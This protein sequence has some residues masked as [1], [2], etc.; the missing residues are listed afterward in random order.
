MDCSEDIFGLVYTW[1][2][3]SSGHEWFLKVSYVRLISS[4]TMPTTLD[5]PY[6]TVLLYCMITMILVDCKITNFCLYMY[7]CQ[8]AWKRELQLNTSFVNSFSD[9]NCVVIVPADKLVKF[10]ARF[11]FLHWSYIT[12]LQFAFK[13]SIIRFLDRLWVYDHTI[14]FFSFIAPTFLLVDF[15]V[16]VGTA[17]I[18]RCWDKTLN[19]A[20]ILINT[21]AWCN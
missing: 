19:G 7:S 5:H 17:T 2:I 8:N 6:Y 12:T 14:W 3:L 15:L 18:K 11:W 4:W 10:Y 1:P 21:S 16:W 9:V 20:C 13:Y